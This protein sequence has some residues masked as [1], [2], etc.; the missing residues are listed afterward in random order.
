MPVLALDSTT[1]LSATKGTKRAG[2]TGEEPASKRARVETPTRV[3][4]ADNPQ[5][6]L[7]RTRREAKNRNSTMRDLLLKSRDTMLTTYSI[8]KNNSKGN[9]TR[10][11]GRARAAPFKTF[12]PN[13]RRISPN[14]SNAM[15]EMEI[16]RTERSTPIDSPAS[17]P[18]VRD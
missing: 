17:A 8:G 5:A 11:V 10:P 15:T 12:A 7:S 6:Y 2:S 18:M 3:F 4:A 14:Q 1:S 13:F 9:S 16:D